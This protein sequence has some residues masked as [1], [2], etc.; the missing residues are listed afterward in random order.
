[1]QK[2]FSFFR[3]D[4]PLCAW[5]GILLLF[6]R[7]FVLRA[8]ISF[9]FAD[10]VIVE[11]SN[12]CQ[13]YS[14]LNTSFLLKQDNQGLL[15]DAREVHCVGGWD[16]SLLTCEDPL[17]QSIICS[18][19]M[20]TRC[21]GDRPGQCIDNE[22]LCDGKYDCIDRSDETLATCISVQPPQLTDAPDT[23]ATSVTLITLLLLA[24]GVCSL[25]AAK[26]KWTQYA[27]DHWTETSD[28]VKEGQ[29]L[30]NKLDLAAVLQFL[31]RLMDYVESPNDDDERWPLLLHD[32]EA[33]HASVDWKINTPILV[34]MGNLLFDA[35]PATMD[36]YFATLHELEKGVHHNQDVAVNLCLK[37]TYGNRSVKTMLWS[38]EPPIIRKVYALI[39]PPVC[40]RMIRTQWFKSITTYVAVVAEMVSFYLDFVKDWCILYVVYQQLQPTSF[41]S[42]QGQ[43]VVL[44]VLFILLPEF[45]KG[46]YFSVKYQQTLDV[47]NVIFSPLGALGLRIS[48]VLCCPFVPAVLMIE[49]CQIALAILQRQAV[50]SSAIETMRECKVELA[51]STMDDFKAMQDSMEKRLRFENL[52]VVAK[53]TE[54][55]CETFFQFILQT[56]LVIVALSSHAIRLNESIAGIF[57]SGSTSGILLTASILYAFISLVATREGVES[58]TKEGFFPDVGKVT[59]GFYVLLSLLGKTLA[60]LVYFSPPLGMLGLSVHWHF[61]H[62]KYANGHLIVDANG[63]TVD[64]VWRPVATNYE[65]FAGAP[66][67]LMYP[68]YAFALVPVQVMAL[69]LIKKWRCPAFAQTRKSVAGQFLHI[70]NC[71]VFPDTLSDWD[72]L[73]DGAEADLDAYTARWRN[74]IMPELR[75]ML[76]WHTCLNLLHCL[77]LFAGV[78]PAVLQRARLLDELAA[79]HPLPEETLARSTVLALMVGAPLVLGLVIPSLQVLSLFLYYRFGHPWSR[80]FKDFTA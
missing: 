39:F 76:I 22:R 3:H 78:G 45:V 72:S 13:S 7:M 70:C 10:L 42:L 55:T 35:D 40:H 15:C 46:L 9:G 44:M 54:M 1:M 80:L 57:Y 63:S 30:T 68:M 62:I 61:G 28:R 26:Q 43:V 58:W 11:A 79:V 12:H 31:V 67:S 34:E 48:I 8:L 71:I 23:H 19:P 14:S 29:L 75:L 38:S 59:F 25:W 65:V 73:V 66:S 20:Q 49:R 60:I 41:W 33:I 56:L 53:H 74:E 16:E 5:H 50:L 36:N 37:H 69:W 17:W 2:L 4:I 64:D 77:P 24:G 52:I 51:T 27:V 32:F 21:L 47:E 6:K 18:R